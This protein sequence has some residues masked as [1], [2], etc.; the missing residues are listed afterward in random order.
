MNLNSFEQLK[1]KIGDI[2]GILGIIFNDKD[3][4]AQAFVHSSF[5]NE[6]RNGVGHNERLEFLGDAILGAI[7]ANYIYFRLQGAAE[8]QLS[9]FKAALVDAVACERYLK[10]LKL[11]EFLLLGRGE[12]RNRYEV[13]HSIL[14]NAFEA[15]VGA[16]FLDKGFLVVEQFFLNHFKDIL[17]EV[18]THPV[19]NYKAELQDLFQRKYQK[20]PQYRVVEEM[21]PAHERLFLVAVFFE[22]R[23]LARGAGSS[24]KEAE[25]KAAREALGKVEELGL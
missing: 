8:G 23:E 15:I 10:E 9:V 11:D 2:E 25:Y 22:D 1:Q 16:I 24:K 20:I 5:V 19:R 13:R 6:Y 12:K 3:L 4:L 7:V 17:E 21:G 14:A 18:I